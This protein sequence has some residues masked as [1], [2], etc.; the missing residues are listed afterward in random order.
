MEDEQIDALEKVL[1]D[2]DF[3]ENPIEKVATD[4]CT[5]ATVLSIFA[6]RVGCRDACC[7]LGLCY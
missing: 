4:E 5:H 3:E 6:G 1:T 2:H 7:V